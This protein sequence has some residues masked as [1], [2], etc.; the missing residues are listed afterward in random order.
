MRLAEMQKEGRARVEKWLQLSLFLRAEPAPLLKAVPAPWR[1][2]SLSKAGPAR[3][4][5]I[6]VCSL[7][8]DCNRRSNTKSAW[9]LVFRRPPMIPTDRVHTEQRRGHEGGSDEVLS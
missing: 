6:F 2:K 9:A 7:I 5:A 8:T 3:L 1:R 4:R